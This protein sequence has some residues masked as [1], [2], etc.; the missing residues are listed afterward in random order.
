MKREVARFLFFFGFK[1]IY[2]ALLKKLATKQMLKK[3]SFI[4]FLIALAIVLI[5][6]PNIKT[7]IAGI[8]ILLFGMI[9][10]EDGFR[11]FTKGPLQNILKKA[12]DK[13]H[14]SIAAGAFITA[15]IQ[16]SSLVTVITISFI[17]AG[18]ISLSGGIGLVFGANLGT[19]AT[20]WLIAAF[21]LKIKISALA[22]PMIIFGFV[23]SF[24]KNNQLKGI[25]NVLAGLGFFF[26]GI[27]YMKEGFDVFKDQIDLTQ[28]AVAGFLGYIIYTFL[29]I[30]ITTI[31]QS[32]SATL[33]L[34]LTAL[35]AGQI[36]Y[37]NALAIAIGANIGTTIT[38]I[39]GA[40]NSNASGKR[41]AIAH[42]IFNF[43][44][45]VIALIL[46]VP[47]A[48]FVD[49][50]SDAMH[51]ASDNY[52]LKLAVFH[53]IFN[54]M[55]VLLMIP[56]IP[57]L[58]V[59]LLSLFKE[60]QQKDIHEAKY[61]NE[62]ILQFP[63]TLIESLT[64]ETKYVYKN[65]VFEIVAHGMN[66]HRK[67]IKSTLKINHVI[68]GSNTIIEADINQLYYTKVKHIYGVI[69]NY[70][71]RG[72]SALKL[73]AKQETRLTQLKLANRRIIEIIKDTRELSKN[74]TAFI[75][76]ENTDVKNEYDKFRKKVA[77]VLRVIYLFRKHGPKERYFKELKALKQQSKISKNKNNKRIDNLI[78]EN[79]ISPSVASSLANDN[80]NVND[81]IKKLIQ[82]AELLY[83]EKDVIFENEI[84]NKDL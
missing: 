28:F 48:N 37:E 67:D 2:W 29:G 62:A 8:A 10:L 84:K 4:F 20:A 78:R 44:T 56:L 41:L 46:I 72:Q 61:L 40:V 6:N 7:V 82:V 63:D 12:T 53:T 36:E 21:G 55:G 77:K 81:L 58:E 15:F 52:T 19:T 66:I 79:L 45:G 74:M 51:I 69:L 31:L 27:F 70:I 65:S 49:F 57:K 18:L 13:L 9:M 32:S 43:S 38:A 35:A 5:I 71:V 68:K 26:L 50:L 34:I 64:E 11:V 54:F 17:S 3:A 47:L 30:V 42:L 16:S 39:L 22:M 76:S 33:A 75:D 73:S 60:K 80:Y 59:F 23:F 24:K 25:G 1:L 14:K 83:S